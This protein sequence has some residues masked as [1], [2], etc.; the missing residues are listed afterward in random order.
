MVLG[1][2]GGESVFETFGGVIMSLKLS[3][4]SEKNCI[5]NEWYQ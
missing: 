2:R 1:E 4:R 3:V 5:M